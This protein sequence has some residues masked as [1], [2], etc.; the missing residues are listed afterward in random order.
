MLGVHQADQF[1]VPGQP[2][3]PG[4]LRRGV[5]D[6]RLCGRGARW[7]PRRWTGRP[8][9]PRH[10]GQDQLGTTAPAPVRLPC[11][12]RHRT[13]A[14]SRHPTRRHQCPRTTRSPRR[15]APAPRPGCRSAGRSPADDHPGPGPRRKAP[16]HRRR[17]RS[18]GNDPGRA[19]LIPA[20][21]PGPRETAGPSPAQAPQLPA[22]LQQR[23][24]LA[25]QGGTPHHHAGP[26]APQQN[27][28]IRQPHL[29]TR[30]WEGDYA[31][32]GRAPKLRNAC[33][34]STPARA[35]CE[36]GVG[37]VR[38]GVAGP[39]GECPVGVCWAVVGGLV[40]AD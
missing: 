30:S 6:A 32:D 4:I 40:A 31:A 26:G 2:A 29:A 38:Y 19:R 10:R 23:R 34:I 17:W 27:R 16:A 8:P 22:L 37:K 33:V 20:A 35:G 21:T 39:V 13:A 14:A 3:D 25:R 28:F 12:G 9:P 24:R 5:E 7:R 18:R 11:P 36:S 15:P 1:R